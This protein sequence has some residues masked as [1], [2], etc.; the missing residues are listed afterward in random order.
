MSWRKYD[1]WKAG[2]IAIGVLLLLVLMTL[3][4]VSVAD[5]TVGTLGLAT[6][7]AAQ[8]TPTVDS[9]M[10]ALNKEK[11]VQDMDQQQ[12][13]LE[14]WFWNYGTALVSS[15]VL[16]VAG[17][18]TLFRYLRDQRNEREKQR[19]DRQ[20]ERERRAEER[21]Q[22]VV[23]GL[24]SE[25]EEA[26]VGAAITLR[27]FLLPGYEQFYRQVFDLAVAH[28]RLP[29]T[30]KLQ[31]EENIPLPLNTLNQALIVVFKEA[32]PLA[33]S[34]N[35]RSRQALD[36]TGIQLDNSFLEDADLKKVWMPRASLREANL[37]GA[38][39]R[40]AILWRANLSGAKLR[41]TNLSD[42]DLW[43]VNFSGTEL[44]DANLSNA[45]L[46]K[47]NLEDALTLKNTDLRRATGLT[48]DQLEACKAKGAIIDEDA[49]TVPPQAAAA[50]TTPPQNTD[51]QTPSTQVSLPTPDTDGSSGVPSR[52]STQ[53]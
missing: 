45:N 40:G 29:R 7:G 53:T 30:S 39:L 15:L 37:W 41:Y 31:E 32:F 47:T 26:R 34:E 25:R 49:T 24:G 9:T 28:L 23:E 38:D 17:A 33:R 21:F 5:A 6:P 10:T 43:K 3:V 27:T 51:A 8:V 35:E 2:I 14:N 11:L 16:A 13:T 50:P 46:K 12:H 22:K 48:K 19:E 18:F 36:A 20:N 1:L 44:K 4:S 42:A 52:P